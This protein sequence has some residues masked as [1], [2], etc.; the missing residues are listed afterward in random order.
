MIILFVIR[1]INPF[2]GQWTLATVV[3]PP[4]SNLSGIRIENK[5]MRLANLQDLYRTVQWGNQKMIEF[6]DEQHG[7]FPLITKESI[8]ET[9]GIPIESLESFSSASYAPSTGS[10]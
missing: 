1:S 3:A 6:L 10:S 8:C 4:S 2:I 5:F 9:F 7:Q